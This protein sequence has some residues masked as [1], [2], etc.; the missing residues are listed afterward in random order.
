MTD[1]VLFV[2]EVVL[3]TS[4]TSKLVKKIS[5][6]GFV[7]EIS[8]DGTEVYTRNAQTVANTPFN[9]LLG[10]NLSGVNKIVAIVH[11]NYGSQEHSQTCSNIS[12]TDFNIEIDSKD[13][14]NMNLRTHQEAY[15]MLMDNFNMGGNDYNTGSLLAISDWLD[16]YKIY[17]VDLSRQE[18]F[19][20]DP[21]VSQQIRIRGTPSAAGTLKVY[22]FK[23]KKTQIDFSNPE[24]TRTIH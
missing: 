4:E 15:R 13:Y 11:N 14:F 17:A 6:G 5:S 7:Q 2:P 22:I 10:T 1:V 21:N 3:P 18:V 16:R 24:K 12:V 8:W 23:N 9:E 19:E 20:A